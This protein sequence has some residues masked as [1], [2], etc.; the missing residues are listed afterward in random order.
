M[1]RL[2][3]HTITFF[4]LSLLLAGCG[5]YL[6]NAEL[7]QKEVSGNTNKVT[8]SWRLEDGRFYFYITN[9]PGGPSNLFKV[10]SIDDHKLTFIP[11]G[12]TSSITITQP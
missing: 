7:R 11:D 1:D 6:R 10:I 12:M 2:M 5:M 9:M 4:A 3:K 8:G